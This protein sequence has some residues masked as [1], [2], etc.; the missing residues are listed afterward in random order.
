MLSRSIR[1]HKALWII[2]GLLT[3]LTTINLPHHRLLVAIRLGVHQTAW[4][5]AA[6][7]LFLLSLKLLRHSREKSDK[8]PTALELGV[9][10]I[11]MV[12]T[13]TCIDLIL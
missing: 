4:G 2:A 1:W 3:V 11:F 10:F 13:G 8:A 6:V 7:T 12:F 9:V 5:I